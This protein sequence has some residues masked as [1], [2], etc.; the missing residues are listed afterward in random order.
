MLEW[1]HHTEALRSII[2]RRCVIMSAVH[3][4]LRSVSWVVI[5]EAMFCPIGRSLCPTNDSRLASELLADRALVCMA[6]GTQPKARPLAPRLSRMSTR[7]FRARTS[8][9]RTC[10]DG[11]DGSD[12]M[13]GPCG[14]LPWGWDCEGVE[15]GM[16]RPARADYGP[17]ARED[18]QLLPARLLRVV[19]LEGALS[20][21]PSISFLYPY[22]YPLRGMTQ[23]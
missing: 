14:Q 9:T 7:R 13:K 5:N 17:R 19:L 22:P 2:T 11:M 6:A 4:R 1:V 20:C 15:H 10:V 3:S 12:L 23:D 8:S 21:M 18:D 16:P